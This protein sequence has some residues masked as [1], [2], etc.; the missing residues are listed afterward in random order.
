MKC[1][2]MRAVL[3]LVLIHAIAGAQPAPEPSATTWT[4]IGP[5]H[6]AMSS[7]VPWSEVAGRVRDI[8][9]D[10]TGII[11]IATGGGGVWKRLPGATSWT[12]LTDFAPTLQARSIAIDPA[13]PLTLY[14]STG[15]TAADASYHGMGIL[16]STDGGATWTHIVGPFLDHIASNPGAALGMND[17]GARIPVIVVSPTDRNVLLASVEVAGTA[18]AENGLYRST[19]GGFNWTLVPDLA[20]RWLSSLAFDP[21][22]GNVAYAVVS[23]STTPGTTFGVYKSTDAGRTWRLHMGPGPAA[24]SIPTTNFAAGSLTISESDPRV[25]YVGAVYTSAGLLALEFY[26][27]SD[28]GATWSHLRGTPPC[29][30]ACIPWNKVVV[31]PRDPNIVFVGGA[32]HPVHVTIDSGLTWREI[33]GAI[34][35]PLHDDVWDF[36]F[37]PDGNTVYVGHDGGI[38]SSNTFRDATVTWTAMNDDL[39]DIIFYNTVD[40]DSTRR[41]F[42]VG[43]AQDLPCLNF[44]GSLNWRAVPFGEGAMIAYDGGADR[45]Y[46]YG[47]TSAWNPATREYGLTYSSSG[48]PAPFAEPRRGTGGPIAI[49]RN[50]PSIQ[51]T[52]TERV[53]QTRDAQGTWT[54]ISPVLTGGGGPHISSI[55]IAAHAPNQVCAGT[56]NGRVWCTRDA[57]RDTLSTWTDR[58]AGLPDRYVMQ[59]AIHKFKE[60]IIGLAYS[61]YRGLPGTTGGHVYVSSDFGAT[62]SDITGN[63]PNAPVNGIAF[64]EYDLD[65][66]IYVATDEGVFRTRDRATWARVATGLPHA[67]ASAVRLHYASRTLYVPTMGRGMWRLSVPVPSA[68]PGPTIALNPWRMRFSAPAGGPNPAPQSLAIAN[69]GSPTLGS[70]TLNWTAVTRTSSGG[71]WLRTT[72]ATGTDN[73]AASVSV[74]VT[75]LAAGRYNGVVR[76]SGTAATNGPQDVLVLLEVTGAARA[77]SGPAA[78]LADMI[79]TTTSAGYVSGTKLLE[80]TRARFEAGQPIA[81]CNTMRTFERQIVLRTTSELK[82]ETA[83]KLLENAAAL[84]VAMRCK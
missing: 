77:M 10:P 31:H 61:G 62:W 64:D 25:L 69:A 27:T 48:L 29:Y 4:F 14:V 22:D 81:A 63:L 82:T 84:F 37:S 23:G 74:D 56:S 71:S 18:I 42:A 45:F 36:A 75:G 66:A 8:A 44:T 57:D 21:R 79:A 39:G 33:R 51:Y 80:Q 54:P 6:S 24:T 32:G 1:L 38:V 52:G 16:K 3:L 72:P 46:A 49:N 35:N 60:Y 53:Y 58:S 30:G 59:V 41:D 34:P 78:M 67:V 73:A 26:R 15:H 55:A 9:V 47:V 68:A 40:V 20:G 43:C 65:E 17:G 13:D 19:D 28:A 83:D 76:V 50:N 5:T 11:Y 70:T 7:W 12:P 2:L